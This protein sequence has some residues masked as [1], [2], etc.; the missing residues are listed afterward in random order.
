MAFDLQLPRGMRAVVFAMLGAF[1]VTFALYM[2]VM[3][4]SWLGII[5]KAQC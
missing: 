3:V 1:T 5:M 4:A 2:A